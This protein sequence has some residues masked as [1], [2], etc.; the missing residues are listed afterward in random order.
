[1]AQ[2]DVQLIRRILQGDQDAFSALV[3]KY[4]KGAHALAWRKIGDFHIAQEITQDA[5]LTAYKKLGTLRNHNAFAGWLYVI[6]ARLSSDWLRRNRLPMES[7]DADN[8]NA[9]DKVSY[10]QYVAEEQ[11]TEADETR[12][13][14]VK[15]LLKKLPESERTVI[16]LHYLGEMTIKAVSEFLG[17]SPNTVK[18]RLRRARNRLKK[19]EGIIRENLGSFQLTN[20]LTENIMREVS[21]LTPAAPATSKPMVPWAALGAAAVLVMLMLGASNQYLARFQ[22]PYS[23][24]A[25][26]EPTIEIVEAPIV[27]DI[28]SKPTLRKQFGRSAAPSKSIG[29]GTQISEANLRSNAQEDR[30]KFSTTQWTPSNAPPGGH[31][32]DIFAAPEGTVYAVSSIG[33]Y[34]L[35]ADA[36]AWTRINARVPTGKSL[37]PMVENRGVLYIVSADAIFASTDNG[38]TWNA[39]CSRPEGKPVGLVVIDE[40]REPRT[41]T[42]ITL[43]FALRDEGIFRSTDGGTRWESLKNGLT[44]ERISA[45]ATIGKTVFAGTNRGLYRFDS[46]FWRKLPVDMSNAVYSLTVL[47]DSLYV[48]TGLDLFGLTLTEGRSVMRT[49]DSSLGKIFRSRDLGASWTEITPIDESRSLALLPSGI[50]ILAAGETLLALG[51]TEFRSTDG[52]ET[53]TNLGLDSKSFMLSNF[54][55]V[56]VN[57]RTFYKTGV[58]GIHRTTDGGRS[59]HLFMDGVPGTRIED[60]V[61]F[62]NRLYAHTGYEVF[63]SANGGVSWKSVPIDKDVILRSEKQN[64]SRV[65]PSFDSKLLITANTLYFLSPTK[66]SLGIS[67]LSTDGNRLIPVQ[68]VADFDNEVLFSQVSAGS[69][70]NMQK[71]HLPLTDIFLKTGTAVVNNDVFYVE[72]KRELFK[73]RLGDSKWASTGLVDTSEQNDEDLLKGF[74]IAV[75]GETVYVGKRDGR[76]FQSLD[77]GSAWRDVTPNL[78]LRFS[79]FKEIVFSGSTVY[80]ATD[81][82]VLVSE[83]GEHWRVIMDGTDTRVVI[84]QFAL[85]STEVYGIGGTGAYRLDTRGGWEQISSKVADEIVALAVTNGRLYSAVKERGIF[86]ISLEEAADNGLTHE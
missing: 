70:G 28:L 23:F 57:E 29:A 84:T 13:E 25:R 4:Q 26:S 69:V 15:E 39:F 86:H 19:E 55:S 14:V 77:G 65:D 31:V 81:E 64:P 6:V 75:S 62:N 27:I 10:S 78:P 34:R 11:A 43:Y 82:G 16:T 8:A 9:V 37:M 18:S 48:A 2:N 58:F 46:G 79:R 47:G 67:S 50:K 33:M 45:V 32:R 59:W 35:P 3:R 1:M 72:Y 80:V 66:S 83:T 20:Q 68:D 44:V 41:Q 71:T 24:E 38:Q 7:L 74:R 54:P 12:R 73:M 42:D 60:L 22:Q 56:A 63:Q 5:F 53:W 40:A 76:L 17:V 21:R 85:D 49:D 30:R 52:G 51:S 36:T 61:V